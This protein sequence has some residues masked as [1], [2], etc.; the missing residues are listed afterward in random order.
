MIY[1]FIPIAIGQC[2]N[3]LVLSGLKAQ[4]V[5]CDINV[6]AAQG[7]VDSQR[8]YCSDRIAGEIKSR[9]LCVSNTKKIKC[10]YVLSI[11]SDIVL[12]D[13]KSIELMHNCLLKDSSLGAVALWFDRGKKN[14][15]WLPHVTLKVMLFKKLVFEKI[16][17]TEHR[18]SC[19]CN[20]VKKQIEKLGYKVRYIDF[21][22]R[23]Y[24][25]NQKL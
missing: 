23:G 2:I 15:L 22:N 13:N 11:D 21:V 16:D 10:D 3:P 6:C 25:I 8:N 18:C 24:E 14:T 1:V 20:T 19:T 9:D 7:I 5:P 17:F 12:T 4:T